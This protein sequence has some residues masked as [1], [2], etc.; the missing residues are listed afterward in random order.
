MAD[1]SLDDA[2]LAPARRRRRAAPTDL[3]R[4]P[5][6]VAAESGA[7]AVGFEAAPVAARGVAAGAAAIRAALKTM[8][9]SPGVYRMLDRKG[10]AH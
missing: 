8:P 5:A 4:A 9:A 6:S 7:P 3:R 2:V 10:D 1:R